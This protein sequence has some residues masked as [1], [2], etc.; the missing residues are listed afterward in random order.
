M[1]S[2]NLEMNQFSYTKTPTI[3]N[4]L[5]KI[6]ALRVELLTFPLPPA[7]ELKYRWE[8]TIDRI[9]YVLSLYGDPLNKPTLSKKYIFNL[10]KTHVVK[11]LSRD[12]KEVIQFKRVLDTIYQDWLVSYQALTAETIADLYKIIWKNRILVSD[13]E[14]DQKLRFIDL[15]IEHPVIQAA[16]SQAFILTQKPFAAHNEEFSHIVFLL[17]LYK[18]GFDLRGMVAIERY[19]FHE[20]AFYRQILETAFKEEN[21]SVWL[22]YV[23]DAMVKELTNVVTLLRDQQP[24]IHDTTFELSNRQKAI[25]A[26]LDQPGTKVTNKM[27]Q[28]MFHISQITASRDLGKLAQLSLIFPIGKGRST[29]YTRV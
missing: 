28:D 15:R 16:L 9:Y 18:N 2:L 29:A 22:E 3:I 25:L 21:V 17:N 19:Y 6:N 10:F 11:K 14:L 13:G 23:T 26:L 1:I 4:N 5:E 8:I 20:R 24:H 12:Q 27:I 7:H